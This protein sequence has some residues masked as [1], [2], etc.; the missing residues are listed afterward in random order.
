VIIVYQIITILIAS[1]FV[2]DLLITPGFLISRLL[3]FTYLIIRLKVKNDFFRKYGIQTDVLFFYILLAYFYG[4]TAILNSFFFSRI[5]S[6]LSYWDQ[7]IFGFQPSVIFSEKFNHPLFSEL[8]Y[9]GYFSYYFIP[10]SAFVIIWKKKRWY[11]DEFAFITISAYFV[12]F[13][14]FIVLPAE[15]PQFYFPAPL[16]LIEAH[17]PFGFI[18]KLIQHY[19]EA[20]TAAFP[21]A[22]VGVSVI[23]LILLFK[24]HKTLFKI[25]LPFCILL[26]FST[27]YIKA[28]YFVDV[29][30]GLISAI[31]VLFIN[32]YIY[33][34]LYSLSTN[35]NYVDRN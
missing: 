31:L 12:Y 7:S 13:L 34:K 16:N 23:V 30:A 8:M 11:F 4:E 6:T 21:S 14:I 32:K 28:H 17:G 33:R 9:F 29:L 24:N 22:H 15:G 26:M 3:V 27:V 5:D 25:L 20:P 2:P 10:L 35:L 19:G 1:I 18:Q